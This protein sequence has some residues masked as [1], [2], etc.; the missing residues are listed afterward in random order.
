MFR[1][2][3]K[4]PAHCQA[5][6]LKP[7]SSARDRVFRCSGNTSYLLI[8]LLGGGGGGGEGRE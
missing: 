8:L 3:T 6:N 4:V 7:L 2:D 1:G 5:L